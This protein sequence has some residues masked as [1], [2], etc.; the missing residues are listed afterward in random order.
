MR[1]A[2]L[3][4]GELSDGEESFL[5]RR[6]GED[7]LMDL[8]GDLS[9]A[10][11]PTFFH[12]SCFLFTVSDLLS[13]TLTTSGASSSSS[14]AF[15]SSQFTSLSIIAILPWLGYKKTY[16]TFLKSSS[17]CSMPVSRREI[18]SHAKIIIRFL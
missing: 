9:F 3:R 17:Y 12:P 7:F 2:V 18:L 6:G 13:T 1:V 15:K 4:G 10:P 8:I 11:A 16:L 5:V 14:G